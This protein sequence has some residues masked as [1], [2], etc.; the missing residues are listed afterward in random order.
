MLSLL[1]YSWDNKNTTT[2]AETAYGKNDWTTA[3]LMKLLNPGYDS[4]SVGGSLYYNAKSGTCYDGESNAT[5]S[6]DFTSTGLKNDTTRN[7]IEEVVW[8]LGGTDA[9]DTSTAS[10]FYTAERGTTGTGR[11]RG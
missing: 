4:L 1:S 3:R 7:A 8:N 2:G 10:M 9:W 11:R 5:T 6:C